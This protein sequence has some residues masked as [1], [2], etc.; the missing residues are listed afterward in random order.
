M[1]PINPL[2][3]YFFFH[4]KIIITL[5][6]KSAA[7]KTLVTLAA[8]TALLN[9]TFIILHTNILLVNERE[10]ACQMMDVG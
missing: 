1:N 5:P 10:H 7:V 9:H 2:Q 3:V 8:L 6:E 4:T